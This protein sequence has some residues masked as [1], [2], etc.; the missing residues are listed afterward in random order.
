[1][2]RA[3]LTPQGPPPVTVEPP[4]RT[5][6]WRRPWIV[7]LWA[8]CGAF[9]LWR[10]PACL[11]FT[12]EA[13]LVVLRSHTHYLL[14]SAHVV[15]GTV[16]MVCCCLQVWPWLRTT[17]PAVHRLTGR[18]YVIVVV[19]AALLA[20]VSSVLQ[21]VPVP[22][23]IGNATLA[24]LWLVTTLAGYR[25]ARRRRFAEHRRWMLR[26]FALCFSIVV[27]RLWTGVL[28]AALQPALEGYYGGDAQALFVDAGVAGIWISWVVN[29]L[30]VEW[31][32]ERGSRVRRAVAR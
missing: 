8:L 26:S 24:V 30:V 23:R 12:P 9:L 29:L 17:R 25:A 4:A 32:I 5:P 18:I 31:W 27:N 19:P 7:P 14:L 20:L 22:G 16:T 6:W 13:S 28:V 21:D 11:G 10:T 15:M 3:T 1:M 2:T